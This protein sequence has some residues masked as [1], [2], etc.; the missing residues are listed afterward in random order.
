[1]R[2]RL[3]ELEAVGLGR[4]FWWTKRYILLT[5]G[6]V[7]F[8]FV[9]S[10]IMMWIPQHLHG[11]FLLQFILSAILCSPFTFKTVA[12]CLWWTSFLGSLLCSIGAVLIGPYNATTWLLAALATCGFAIGVCLRWNAPISES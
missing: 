12:G 1:M 8:G 10:L 3:P 6:V 4:S 7:G 11:M 2:V 9:T 5:V